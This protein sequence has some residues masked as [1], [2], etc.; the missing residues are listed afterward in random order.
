LCWSNVKELVTNIEGE[1]Q[2]IINQIIE[3][4]NGDLMSG[5]SNGDLQ[6]WNVKNGELI[7]TIHHVQSHW[8]NMASLA[9]GNVACAGRNGLIHILN[10]EK[11]EI[12]KSLYG[13]TD[14]PELLLISPNN[15]ASYDSIEGVLNKWNVKSGHVVNRLKRKHL[16]GFIVLPNDRL[17]AIV[18]NRW[19]HS[20]QAILVWNS[21]T[22][23]IVEIPIE[24]ADKGVL[25]ILF[26]NENLLASCQYWN[27]IRIWNF[28]SGQLVREFENITS[29]ERLPLFNSES[30]ATFSHA[31][32]SNKNTEILF[33]NWKTDGR[34][35]KKVEI[36]EN[37]KD[38]RSFMEL[39]KSDNLAIYHFEILASKYRKHSR[40]K[41]IHL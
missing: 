21:S 18:Y 24:S 13:H 30:L 29:S 41:Y 6:V 12:I 15:L 9:D 40:I 1:H 20:G 34:L 8:F 28:T 26:L 36:K 10:L 27:T 39:K 37:L 14:L 16:K 23:E 31:Y 2:F 35:V 33:W 17:A 7:K 32:G 11:E 5:S 22:D 4:E 38:M 19:I 3:L 25:E